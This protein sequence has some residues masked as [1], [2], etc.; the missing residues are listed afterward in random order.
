MLFLVTPLATTSTEMFIS[1]AT[2]TVT[3][4][5]IGSKIKKRMIKTEYPQDIKR[6][7]NSLESSVVKKYLT[8]DFH[9]L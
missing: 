5:C 6:L 1:V 3:L 9:E 8:Q 2:A 4:V 7:N